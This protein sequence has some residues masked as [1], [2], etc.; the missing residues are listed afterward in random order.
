M[1]TR[2]LWWRGRSC[3]ITRYVVCGCAHACVHG[4]TVLYATA[5][6]HFQFWM[7]LTL[8][9]PTGPTGPTTTQSTSRLLSTSL[10]D[11]MAEAAGYTTCS[12][13]ALWR[14]D[15]LLDT[16]QHVLLLDELKQPI[17]IMGF[18]ADATL[19]K[20][21]LSGVGSALFAAKS[22]FLSR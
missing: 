19:W 17:T 7:R 14:A 11:V 8:V 18:R 15:R 9:A 2:S 21:M 3:A 13:A 20:L 16:A 6:A 12:Q 1:P 22:F 4:L 10:P 5:P